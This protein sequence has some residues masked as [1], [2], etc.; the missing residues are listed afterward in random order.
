MPMN[1][2]RPKSYWK[3]AILIVSLTLG[4]GLTWYSSRA[5]VNHPTLLTMAYLLLVVVLFATNIIELPKTAT[6][7]VVGAWMK[8]SDIVKGVS[9]VLGS[10]VWMVLVRGLVPETPIGLA[11]I[12]VP[13]AGLLVIGAFFMI[14]G[15]FKNLQ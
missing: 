4:G 14:K 12:L 11:V 7:S 9:C 13:F 5:Q 3:V 6:V 10:I 15:V 1:L 2:H 8:L